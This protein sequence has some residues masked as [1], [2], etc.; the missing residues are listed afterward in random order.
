MNS[1]RGRGPSL[2]RQIV[3]WY[4]V[5]L[6][7]ALGLF[8]GLTYVLLLGALERQGEIA[9]RQT[10]RTVE[11]IIVPQNIPRIETREEFVQLEDEAGRPVEALVRE[12]LLA[13]GDVANVVVPRAR[14][15]E[16]RALRSFL[17]IALLLVP[18]TAAAAAIG[19][20]ALVDR[21][22]APLHRLV[23]ASREIGIGDLSR[24]V[25]EPR[26]PA[27]LR[28]LARSF[29][30]M[31]TRLEQAVATLRRFTADASHELRTPLTSIKGTVQVALARP[32]TADEL[33]DTLAEVIEETEWMLHLVDG[34][35][36]LARG[37]ER[38]LL[39]GHESLDL[40]PMLSDSVEMGRA[41]AAGKP[42]E[43]E[44]EA[45]D[46]LV[47]DGAAPALRQVFLNLL[48]NAAKF[49]ERGSITVVARESAPPAGAPNRGR[50]VEVSVSDTGVGIP[51]HELP[52]VFDRFY[53][54]DEA[55]A[56]QPGTGL[57][58][59]IAD[60][61]V[62]QHGGVISAESEPGRGST[63]RVFLPVSEEARAA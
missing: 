22:L 60:L 54:G 41:L 23:T 7:V 1:G 58:L 33:E 37:E 14:S 2:R 36:T 34:L 40:V 52:R 63:F 11:Q 46:S 17:L 38:A 49:T 50:W 35:L 25:Q 15:I 31:L 32:R 43:V 21:L 42:I 27:E 18:L 29:N 16:V 47:I 59:A 8:V 55:R 20:Y 5:V 61:V 44:L 3:V 6:V 53:R 26:E 30:G 28:E 48:T 57:G 62:Q 4:S 45:P 24:R 39:D 9:V 19:G 56:S 51:Q 12:T 10:A 13:T